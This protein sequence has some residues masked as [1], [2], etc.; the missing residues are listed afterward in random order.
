MK[1]QSNS[2]S[3]EISQ[4]FFELWQVVCKLRSPQGCPWDREQTFVSMK[5]QFL[6]EVYEF[7]D[8][9]EENQSSAM[10]EELG[11][12]FFHLLFFAL[13]GENAGRFTLAEVLDRIR[14]KLVRRH[15]HVF[16][17]AA[18]L[19]SEQVKSNWEMI[20]RELE[21]KV[22]ASLLDNVPR[23]LPPL[24]KAYVYGK[25]GGKV[26]FD[27]PD[28][29]ALLPKVREELKEVEEA[30]A[31]GGE[32]LEEELGDL[33]SVVVNL[34]RKAGF[35]PGRVLHL[36]N[37]KFERRFRFM[38][39]SAFVSGRE[40]GRLGLEEQEDLWEQAKKELG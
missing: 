20:K 32:P 5:G 38:E 15:P 35:D 9:L 3:P 17:E 22:Y 30:L 6:E 19:S 13:L 7:V 14:A 26:G 4:I 28:P 27:W 31:S 40:L 34:V 39:K 36:A 12:L 18:E 25:K 8:A 23:S 33:M 16:A 37:G 29:A 2:A 1:S 24:E 10:A 21:G 11:D